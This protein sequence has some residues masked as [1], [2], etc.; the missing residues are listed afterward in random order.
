MRFEREHARPAIARAR[1]VDQARKHGLVAD[2]HAVE[3]ADRE[4]DRA[5]DAR[6]ESTG[7]EHGRWPE[8][9]EKL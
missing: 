2:V 6:R 9:A 8:G 1:G 5:V 7:D 4:G 3:V